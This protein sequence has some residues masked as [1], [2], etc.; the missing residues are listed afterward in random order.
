MRSTV[1]LAMALL[2]MSVIPNRAM[3]NATTRPEAVATHAPAPIGI[4]AHSAV[5]IGERIRALD[6]RLAASGLDREQRQ[7]E[8]D[9]VCTDA[10]QRHLAHQ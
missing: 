6:T 8:P 2:T 9:E 1:V 5:T 4:E 10:A 7:Q 3:A